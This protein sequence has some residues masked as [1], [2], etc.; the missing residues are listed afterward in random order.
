MRR[1]PGLFQHRV[2][3]RVNALGGRPRKAFSDAEVSL[4]LELRPIKKRIAHEPF[5]R[6]RISLEAFPVGCTTVSS[7]SGTKAF[8]K[9]ASAH[10]PPLVM[11]AAK[12]HLGYARPSLVFGDFLW[13]EMTMVVDDRQWLGIA[14]IEFPRCTSGEEEIVVDVILFHNVESSA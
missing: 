5:H 12:P 14:V 7:A 10:L 1:E 6:P 13:R 2:A 11:I 9:A 3:F 8:L 4:E